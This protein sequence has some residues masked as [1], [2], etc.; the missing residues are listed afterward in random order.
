MLTLLAL[1]ALVV[2]AAQETA[3]PTPSTPPPAAA[4]PAEYQIGPQDILAIS[5]F[6][7]DDL[8][9][10]VVVQADG[11]LTYPL[12]G[13]IPASDKTAKDLERDLTERL[14]KSFIRNPQVT[15]AIREYRSKTVLVAGEIGHPGTYPLAG[16]MTIVEILAKAGPVSP[17]AAAE[18]IVVRPKGES[19]GPVL[20]SE[21]TD[22]ALVE[23]LRV[24]VRAIESGDL[25]ANIVLKPNDTV[26][27][28]QAPKV[29]VSGE[30]NSPGAYPLTPGTTVR[31]ILSLAGGITEDGSTGRI[32][33][34]RTVSGK[35]HESGIKIDDP[36]QAGDTLVV[37]AKIF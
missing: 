5:V 32:R 20:P 6:G 2:P 11:T 7:H 26:F 1:W 17:G 35:P 30:V 18:V 14:G 36:V 29:Y 9:Q 22:S 34:V 15:V 4:A 12:V 37:R 31:Q 10:T 3:A 21:M 8:T 27:V 24:N 25:S 19:H 28:P 33:V 16:G 23:I 13:R